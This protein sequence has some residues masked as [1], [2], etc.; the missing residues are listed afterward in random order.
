MLP[1][2]WQVVGRE[3]RFKDTMFVSP[4]QILGRRFVSEMSRLRRS[5]QDCK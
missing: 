5:S 1:I 4:I 2:S 3:D